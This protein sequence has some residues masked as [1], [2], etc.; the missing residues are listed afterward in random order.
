MGLFFIA[1]GMGVSVD[2]ILADPLKVFGLAAAYLALKA[3]LIYVSGR[4]FRMTHENS[5]RM[6]MTIAQGGEFAFVIFGIALQFGLAPEPQLALLTAVV[7]VSMAISPLMEIA[8]QR[9]L[10]ERSQTT[11]AYDE[12]KD[13]A[14]EIVIAGFGRFGQI[15]GR[16]LRAQGIPFVA[17]DHDPEQI[18]LLRKFG[19][20]VYY[21]DASR[22]DLLQAA[23]AGKAKFFI[24][25]IDDV[26]LS[27]KTAKLVRENFPALKIFARARNRGHAFDLMELGVEQIKR[28]TFD[29][30]VYFVQELLQA[31]GVAARQAETIIEKFKRHDEIMLHEQ[32]K[33]RHDNDILVSVSKQGTAQL[34]A[35]LNEDSTR[36][37]VDSTT[38]T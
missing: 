30:S 31:T 9:L 25:A 12:I 36:T 38:A 26:E 27:V 5:K 1:V 16:V 8:Y 33:V 35:V 28:E 19:N 4:M 21:G 22:L 13:E 23:G 24:L 34:A 3:S 29:S 17:I 14:P 37:Y 2:L 32:F 18:E 20:K 7:T 15:F 10:C 11:P 6:A